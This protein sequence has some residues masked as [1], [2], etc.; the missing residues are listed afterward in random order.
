LDWTDIDATN[1]TYTAPT[2]TGGTTY[3][4]CEVTTGCGGKATS[5]VFKVIVCFTAVQD[6]EENWYCTGNFGDAGYWMTMNLRSTRNNLYEDLTAISTTPEDVSKKYYYYPNQDISL[7]TTHPEY[8]LLYTWAAA[9]GR[10]AAGTDG[11]DARHQ[12]I[13]PVGWHLPSDK[14]WAKLEKEVAS[15]PAAYSTQTTK[16]ALADTYE[17]DTTTAWRPGPTNTDDSDTWWGRQMKSQTP[18]YAYSTGGTSKGF[19]S[20]GFDALLVGW[21]TAGGGWSNYGSFAMYWSATSTESEKAY[22]RALGSGRSGASRDSS[23]KMYRAS[24][25]CMQD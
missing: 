11:S 17:Y 7:I 21:V 22:S 16:Y 25:R 24:V 23:S 2:T 20:D 10:T 6:K 13:C 5:K 8:G 19:N 14:D 12:G 18:V 4:R 3:Y 15:N 9:S 1:S